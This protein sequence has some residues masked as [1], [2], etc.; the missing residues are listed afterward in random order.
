MNKIDTEYNNKTFEVKENYDV[1]ISHSYLDRELVD[2]LYS[3]F[4]ECGYK[5]FIDWKN[6]SLKDREKVDVRVALKLKIY[7]A[8]SKGLLYI[9]T[10]N[11]SDS[12]WCPWELGY[13]DGLKSRV[14]ILPILDDNKNFI[15]QEYLSLYP[16]IT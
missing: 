15:G 14:A 4:E 10:E 13:V 2:A 1:F 8:Q 6:D 16:Y 11:S 5:V 7:M 3:K 12:K 9:S